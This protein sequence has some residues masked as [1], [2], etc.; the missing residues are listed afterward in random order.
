MGTE[1]S[2]KM[3]ES[4]KITRL[5][6]ETGAPSWNK[7]IAK[8]WIE[9]FDPEKKIKP[10]ELPKPVTEL[11]VDPGDD[12]KVDSRESAALD[13]FQLTVELN[14]PI[15]QPH[16]E[17]FFGAIRGENKLNCPGEVA[18]ASAGTVLAVHDAVREAKKIKL[19]ESQF[20]A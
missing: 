4:P 9:N 11:S 15:H 3:S 7:W 18:L 8:N 16:L 1:G 14:K 2:I 5:F 12:G 17:N 10:W 13:E 6:R 19:D 20:T